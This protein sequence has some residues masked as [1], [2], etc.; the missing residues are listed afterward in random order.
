[1]APLGQRRRVVVSDKRDS[2][3][4]IPPPML[5][6]PV[7]E[8][9]DAT[10]QGLW[11]AREPRRCCGPRQLRP[12]NLPQKQR[13]SVAM[14]CVI[15]LR[16][17]VL[18]QALML[19][20]Y[21]L[22]VVSQR[23]CSCANKG[24][25]SDSGD[26]A[27]SEH[28]QPF[29]IVCSPRS[30]STLLVEALDAH[31]QMVCK[32]E[33]LNPLY[34][35]YGN[36]RSR[37]W[38][39]VKLHWL[40]MFTPPLC[41]RLHETMCCG[42]RS[43][44][45]AAVAIGAKMFHVHAGPGALECGAT[46]S[47]LLGALAHH[48]HRPLLV[49]LYRRCMLSS[50]LSLSRAFETDSW[51]AYIGDQSRDGDASHDRGGASLSSP[52]AVGLAAYRNAELGGWKDLLSSLA[53]SGWLRDDLIVLCYEDDI[54][55]PHGW[56]C[57]RERLATRLLGHNGDGGLTRTWLDR[58]HVSVVQR[59]EDPVARERRAQLVAELTAAAAHAGYEWNVEDYYLHL[60]DMVETAFT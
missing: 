25:G 60:H 27:E 3:P 16:R 14:Q 4:A 42:W 2:V 13:L 57:A 19:L 33:I 53:E 59:N 18:S 34:E 21:S 54:D 31:P 36:V 55:S 52:T 11:R 17:N 51:F 7:K 46:V 41:P 9:H 23:V 35:V 37:P 43:R 28:L 26:E 39:R 30:G 49:L 38:W 22:L 20:A 45:N 6:Q 50:Y 12:F 40:A 47:R 10:A 29:V 5:Q 56:N 24:S 44:P 8:E 32:G 48:R 1:M 15:W 58:K